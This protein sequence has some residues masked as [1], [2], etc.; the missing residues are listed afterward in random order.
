MQSR[1]SAAPDAPSIVL[2]GNV[3]N[4]GEKK[5]NRFYGDWLSGIIG[6]PVNP[7]TETRYGFPTRLHAF[8]SSRT[9]LNNRNLMSSANNLVLRLKTL[10]IP[11]PLQ[12]RHID[13]SNIQAMAATKLPYFAPMPELPQPLPT[14]QE[15][16]VRQ[17]N[18][19]RAVVADSFGSDLI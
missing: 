11:T 14:D 10:P 12:V 18:T 8:L 7:S 4:R 15:Y 9:S 1:A 16:M 17:S 2:H 5:K 6:C 3:A 19:W 13:S